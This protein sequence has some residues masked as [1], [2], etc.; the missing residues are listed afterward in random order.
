MA[1]NKI[2]QARSTPTFENFE[3]LSD[4]RNKLLDLLI[5]IAN[6]I[7]AKKDLVLKEEFPFEHA[8]MLILWGKPGRGKT[9]LIEALINFIKMNAPDLLKKIYL[10]R[11]NFTHDNM[12]FATRYDDLPIIIID[13]IYSEAL[14][15]DSL[16]PA[17]DLKAFMNFVMDIYEKR[18]LVIITSNFPFKEGIL[19]KVQL[20][21]PQG[22]VTSRIQE[23][24]RSAG[25]F[26][27]VGD[28]FRKRENENKDDFV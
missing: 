26:E 17:T 27:V 18:R 8:R 13:D 28:D 23:L 12:T 16:H 24:F 7:L 2:W 14:T 9:H 25:E 6:N 22:R 19:K 21:D 5:K 20:A 10:S 1:E 4:D 3:A 15:S 11:S